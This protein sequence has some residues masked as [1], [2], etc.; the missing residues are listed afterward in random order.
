MNAVYPEG[1]HAP[2]A[3]YLTEQG[4]AVRVAT[5]DDPEQGLPSGDCQCRKVGCVCGGHG[6]RGGHGARGGHERTI[7]ALPL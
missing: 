2:I 3:N 7:W 6:V 1:M 4:M 5:L